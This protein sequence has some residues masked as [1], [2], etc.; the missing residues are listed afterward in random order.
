MLDAPCSSHAMTDAEISANA[1]LRTAK[2]RARTVSDLTEDQIR[3]K[4]SVDRKA[5]QAYRQRTKDRIA[6]L[7]KRLAD[8]QETSRQQQVHLKSEVETLRERNARLKRCLD[9]IVHL[10]SSTIGQHAHD[11][12]V[13]DKSGMGSRVL[14]Q[15]P[16]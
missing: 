15:P 1:H 16:A 3:Q 6:E 4:R 5:Q 7:E 2:K 13:S 8:V 14:V 9:S 10:A 11:S 12:Y